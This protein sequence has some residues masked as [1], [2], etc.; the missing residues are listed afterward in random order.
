MTNNTTISKGYKQT[1]V[2]IIPQEWRVFSLKESC[3][4]I[5]DGT[6]DTPKPV[7][8][9]VPFL[10][11]VNVKDNRIDYINCLY[12]TEEDH[13]IIYKRCNPEKGDVLVVS[14]GAGVATTA[15]VDVDY[16]FSLK[17][18]ALLKPSSSY[19]SGVYLNYC[20]AC[21]KDCITKTLSSGG[22]QPFLSLAQIGDISIPIPPLPEQHAIAA[23]LSDV[24]ALLATLDQLIA[25]KCDLK[26]AVMQKLL[27]GQTRLPGFSGRWEVKK[28][29][30]FGD[31]VTGGTPPTGIK[32]YWDGD[33][34]W[35]TPTDISSKKDIYESERQITALGL[36][37]IR[38]LPNNSVLITCIASI[39]K[40]AVLRNA[41][42][43]N[44]QINA[45]IPNKAHDADFLYYL[46]ES[47]KQY[48]L[49]NSGIT[50]TMIISKKD[51]SE[52][53]FTIPLKTEQTAI[54]TV[55][56][57]M[58]AEIA[59]LEARRD[60]TR[61]LKQGMMQELLTGRIRLV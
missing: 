60:K 6:H 58:D 25:K 5:T 46:I 45:I 44:Q 57:D 49:C 39:G 3:S 16:E 17:N 20:L 55:L 38:K 31:I 61:A 27:T 4:K 32:K 33:I 51:Y 23:A 41:G 28:T 48:L 10:T 47:K 36:A 42:A 40:N 34:P 13:K 54:A 8:S 21:R 24:D 9:G 56:S 50:A 30:Q 22:A 29:K 26:Q 37:A 18:V 53:D 14:I 43:C 35:V 19:L 2:G 15:L 12:I 59:A 52:L 7:K 1:D 11:A